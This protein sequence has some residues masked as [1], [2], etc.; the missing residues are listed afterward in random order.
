MRETNS[1]D[2]SLSS[3]YFSPNNDGY[4]DRLILTNEDAL[5]DG[6]YYNC[7][8]KR[9]YLTKTLLNNKTMFSGEMLFWDGTD[10]SGNMVSLI[11]IWY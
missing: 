4:L 11:Y 10:E 6:V 2:I 8:F 3:P 9:W 1:G 7:L 5:E